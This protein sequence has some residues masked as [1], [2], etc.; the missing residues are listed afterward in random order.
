MAKRPLHVADPQNAIRIGGEGNV[1]SDLYYRVLNAPWWKVILVFFVAYLLANAVFAVAYASCTDCV[2]GVRSGRFDDAFF[3]S[4]QTISTIG[5]G[6]LYPRT[7]FAEVVVT[8]E[9]IVG[10]FG[11]AVVTGIV[12]SKFALSNARVLFSE[13]VLI[14][15]Y[16]G[17]RALL[18]R[19]ANARGNDIV[20]ASLRAAVLLPAVTAEGETIRRL[21]NLRLKRS[22]SP[23]FALSWLVIHPIDEHS[24]LRALT[25]QTLLENNTAFI[26]SLTGLD[27]TMNDTIHARHIYRAEDVQWDVMFEDVVSNDAAGHLVLDLTKFHDTRAPKVELESAAPTGATSPRST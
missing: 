4:V 12:F 22:N 23:L 8:I 3:F 10:L 18:F 16:D 13:P 17:E 25:P 21:H 26:V 11:F 14:T 9:S 2:E 15:R 7:E 1:L 27:G 19:I 5:Y 6:H 24:P 20:E